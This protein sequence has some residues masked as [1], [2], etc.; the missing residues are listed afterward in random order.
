MEP[1]TVLAIAGLGMAALAL[2]NGIVSMAHGGEADQ[3]GSHLLMFK[4]VGWQSA[5][6]LAVLFGLLVAYWR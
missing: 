3:R 6:V 1:L 2:L 4:R 5:A